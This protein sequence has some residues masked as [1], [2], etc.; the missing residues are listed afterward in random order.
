MAAA[1]AGGSRS[2]GHQA[3]GGRLRD[4][5]GWAAQDVRE[6][7]TSRDQEEERVEREGRRMRRAPAARSRSPSCRPWGFGCRRS[8]QHCE[9]QPRQQSEHERSARA[10]VR[11]SLINVCRDHVRRH[12]PAKRPGRRVRNRPPGR[13]EN[14]VSCEHQRRNTPTPTPVAAP[15]RTTS[16]RSMP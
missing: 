6:V 7:E 16:P 12:E 9:E 1:V 11:E 15:M 10:E 5:L 14:P 8:E 13:T 2:V 4:V 3:G